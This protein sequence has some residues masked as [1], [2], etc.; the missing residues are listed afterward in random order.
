MGGLDT[1]LHNPC[2]T[3]LITRKHDHGATYPS[4]LG[5]AEESHLVTAP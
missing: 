2:D 3:H 4:R 5:E 1:L